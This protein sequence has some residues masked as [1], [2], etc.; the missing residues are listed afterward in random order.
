MLLEPSVA[1]QIVVVRSE[2]RV[3]SVKCEEKRT[4]RIII[5]IIVFDIEIVSRCLKREENT[6]RLY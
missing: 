6:K 3:R 5:I 2:E 4:I 1:F